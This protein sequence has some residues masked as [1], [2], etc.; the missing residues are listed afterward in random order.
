L[1]LFFKVLSLCFKKFSFRKEK[2]NFFAY[3]T[4]KRNDVNK[5]YAKVALV[6]QAEAGGWRIQGQPRLQSEFKA[7]LSYITRFCLKNP[8]LFGN[9]VCFEMCVCWAME[10]KLA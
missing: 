5:S 3:F 7:S 8:Q 10:P 6:V 1:A 4:F 2:L 9:N